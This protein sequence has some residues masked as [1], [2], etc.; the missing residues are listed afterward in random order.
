[1]FELYF[2]DDVKGEKILVFN[3]KIRK[4]FEHELEKGEKFITEARMYH[5]MDEK[6]KILCI[7]EA[8]EVGEYLNDGYTKNIKYTFKTSPKGYHK[9]F[10]EILQK[11]LKGM[12]FR[13]KIYVIKMFFQSRMGLI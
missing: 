7:N 10:K 13:K 3:S 1:M 5:K 9:Y 4:Q 8:I 12:K 6:Y 2:L 11:G